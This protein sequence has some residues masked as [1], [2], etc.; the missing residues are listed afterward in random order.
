MNYVELQAAI[1]DYL[2]RSDIPTTTFIALA[3]SKAYS[4]LRLLDMEGIYETT[5][6]ENQNY[7]QLPDD[8]ISLRDLRVGGT[9]QIYKNPKVFND[10]EG[11]EDYTISDGAL[12][13]RKPGKDETIQLVYYK[14]PASLSSGNLSNYLTDHHPDLLLYGALIHA[15]KYIDDEARAETYQGY[16]EKKLLEIALEEDY[17]RYPA[18]LRQHGSR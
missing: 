17:Q 12:R 15:Y 7:Y 14:R 5:S 13:I 4:A 3:E 10:T 9:S 1:E 6:V 16:Y 18:G 2:A 8:Y 11:D